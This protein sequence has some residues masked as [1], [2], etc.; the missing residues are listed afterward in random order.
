MTQV[1]IDRPVGQ[2]AA[3][4]GD[5]GE[6]VVKGRRRKNEGWR[7]ICRGSFNTDNCDLPPGAGG[8]I[9][10]DR[11]RIEAAAR[12]VL[13]DGKEVE[14]TAKEF[15]LLFTLAREPHRVYRNEELLEEIWGYPQAI[16]TRTLTSHISRVRGKLSRAGAEGFIVNCW[17]VGYSLTASQTRRARRRR[18]WG[19][20]SAGS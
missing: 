11:L 4:I 15:D 18:G 6:W 7:V 3:A 10:I 20:G 2:L 5:D 17:G 13:V 16:T 8:P 19:S 1:V 9:T 14:L 12:R